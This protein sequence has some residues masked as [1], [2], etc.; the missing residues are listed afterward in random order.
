MVSVFEN[1]E[2][3]KDHALTA[4]NIYESSMYGKYGNVMLL[5]D[6]TFK[7]RYI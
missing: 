2:F 4:F 6:S 7:F 5:V 1:L 3:L